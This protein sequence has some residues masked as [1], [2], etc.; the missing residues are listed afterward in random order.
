M[1]SLDIVNGHY[2]VNRKCRHATKPLTFPYPPCSLPVIPSL[3]LVHA[4]FASQSKQ[5]ATLDAAFVI[6][7]SSSRGQEALV[8]IIQE[9]CQR[10]D[11]LLAGCRL[12][13]QRCV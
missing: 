10:I 5:D 4:C 12:N 13:M 8:A 6:R 9:L 7:S 1:D 2:P 11:K 3:D